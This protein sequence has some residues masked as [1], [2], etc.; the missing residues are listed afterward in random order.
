MTKE[1]IKL[2]HRKPSSEANEFTAAKLHHNIIGFI[3]ILVGCLL[4][5]IVFVA[6]GATKESYL[7][8]F[9]VPSNMETANFEN[10][11]II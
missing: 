6:T 10:H 2:I 5:T 11:F 8:Y 3:I 1:F 4:V 7:P 9:I